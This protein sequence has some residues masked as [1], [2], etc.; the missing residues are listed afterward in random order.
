MK[1]APSYETQELREFAEVLREKKEYRINRPYFEISSP[2]YK[3]IQIHKNLNDYLA[4]ANKETENNN[5]QN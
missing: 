5:P 1:K 2:N 4:S 3:V